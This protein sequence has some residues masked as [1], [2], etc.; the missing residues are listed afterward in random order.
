MIGGEPSTCKP[1]GSIC[2]NTTRVM[3]DRSLHC[4]NRHFR[5]FCSCDLDLVSM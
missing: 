4:G 2:Y 3:G 1:H 5:P